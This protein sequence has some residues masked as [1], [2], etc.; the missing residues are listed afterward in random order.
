MDFVLK[1]ISYM[2]KKLNITNFVEVGE[3]LTATKIKETE[4]SYILLYETRNFPKK[5]IVISPE[6][7]EELEVSKIIISIYKE[8][9]FDTDPKNPTVKMSFIFTDS[10]NDVL[11]ETSYLIQPAKIKEKIIS[12]I[13][14]LK[15]PN[16]KNTKS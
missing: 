1:N 11:Q 15:T 5:I 7:F 10:F 16:S 6:T 8:I 9:D 14:T 13:N 2:A 4:K 12:F 3:T